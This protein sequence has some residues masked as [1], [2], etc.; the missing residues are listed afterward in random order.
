M[1]SFRCVGRKLVL[2]VG[3]LLFAQPALAQDGDD[4]RRR[5][6]REFDVVR[7]L[8]RADR[9]EDGVLTERELG[10]RLK[11]YVEEWGIDTSRP[12]SVSRVIKAYEKKKKLEAEAERMR[13]IDGNRRVPKFGTGEELP[14]PP[15][16]AV[17]EVAGANGRLED[18]YDKEM[19][20]TVK[21]YMRRYDENEDG[22]LDEGE[23]RRIRRVL[24]EDADVDKNGKLGEMEIAAALK[25]RMDNGGRDDDDD[26]SRGNR[27]G[28]SRFSRSRPDSG[29]RGPERRP[30]R[31]SESNSRSFTGTSQPAK[32]TTPT[33]TR[34]SRSLTGRQ[35]AYV[36]GVFSR[37]DEDKNGQL[38]KDEQKKISGS[39]KL[40]DVNGD[41]EIDRQEALDSLAGTAQPA[42]TSSRE[43]SSD[44]RSRRRRGR[45]SDDESR[46]SSSSSRRR[47]SS[48]ST[49]SEM[50]YDIKGFQNIPMEHSSRSDVKSDLERKGADRT[51]LSYDENTDGQISM[52]EFRDGKPWTDQLVGKF[53]ILD[54]NDDG[55][56]TIEEFNA[57]YDELEEDD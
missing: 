48:S 34:T 14:P 25:K 28:R 52:A 19:V 56:V 2:L 32:T 46:E 24:G 57:N 17:E 7:Y 27:D 10:G 36:D 39:L 26:R 12:V 44:R 5:R 54:A 15:N 20:D 23:S 30:D 1:N 50:T 40:V 42:E 18:Q 11:E 33:T 3:C 55:V 37:Y 43:E 49:K 53:Q 21:A 13:E 8:E 31:S 9:D 16:F 47:P 45:D 6:E 4:W 22:W 38:S 29:N 51:F 35:T 41:G